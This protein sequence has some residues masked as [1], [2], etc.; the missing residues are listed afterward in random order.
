MGSCLATFLYVVCFDQIDRED[1]P[2]EDIAPAGT[3]EVEDK[4]QAQYLNQMAMSTLQKRLGMSE[5]S[6]SETASGLWFRNMITAL[7]IPGMPSYVSKESVADV[8]T[9]TPPSAPGDT[10]TPAAARVEPWQPEGETIIVR[11]RMRTRRLDGY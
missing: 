9:G 5:A 2:H 11:P 4:K 1:E 6:P 3:Y 7:L 8:Q 10:E